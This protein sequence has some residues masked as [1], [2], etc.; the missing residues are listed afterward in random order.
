MV[1]FFMII[2]Y[3]KISSEEGSYISSMMRWDLF[4]MI[5]LF[6]LFQGAA[7]KGIA[8]FQAVVSLISALLVYIFLGVLVSVY[9][10]GD[11]LKLSFFLIWTVIQIIY[12][13]DFAQKS[14]FALKGKISQIIKIKRE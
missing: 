14:A 10:D 7:I 3:I 5:V 9:Q 12:T 1:S 13:L 6:P 4:L 11:T 8:A 2:N